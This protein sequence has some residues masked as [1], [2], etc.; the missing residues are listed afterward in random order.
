M[1]GVQTCALPIFAANGLLIEKKVLNDNSELYHWASKDPMPTY[2][3]HI[4]ASKYKVFSEWYKKVTNPSDSIP[5]IYYVWEQDYLNTETDGSQYNARHAFRDMLKMMECYSSKYIEY[6]FEK[7]GM[8]AVQPF[9]FGGMEH[10]TLTT[11]NRSW[12]RGWASGGIAHELAHQWFGDLVTCATW[13]DIWINEGGAQ[14]SETIFT[15]YLWGVDEG[16]KHQYNH[17][18]NYL[19]GGGLELRPIYNPPMWDLFNYAVTYNKSSCIYHMLRTL[20]GD[21]VFFPAIRSLLTKFYLQSIETEDFKNHF[22][23]VV[24]NPPVSF[25]TFFDQWIFKPGHPIFEISTT[26]DTKTGNDYIA[27]VNLKQVQAG[28]NIPEVFVVPVRLMFFGP[29]N[30]FKADTVVNSER[31]QSFD[32]IL[33]FIPDSIRIDSL[34]IICEIAKNTSTVREISEEYNSNKIYP[35]PSVNGTIAHTYIKTNHYGKIQIELFDNLGNK[36]KDIYNGT[37]PAGSYEFSFDTSEL[38]SGAYFVIIRKTNEL[39]KLKLTVI[40]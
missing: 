15:E 5:I 11:I 40:K 3:M 35:N 22:K 28:E 2:L 16:Y 33:P 20:L 24:P 13:K 26:I 29:N 4:A 23:E 12:L 25:D 7:Y 6:P 14:W 17:I 8:D 18:R 27:T 1:T 37:L 31:S 34:Q 10:Q 21:E 32:L 38:S 36:V 19:G 30:Q 9:N 39:F